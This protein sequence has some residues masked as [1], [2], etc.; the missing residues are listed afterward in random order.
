MDAILS[1]LFELGLYA[2]DLAQ[3]ERLSD[4]A[5]LRRLPE[6]IRKT[7]SYR[8]RDHVVMYMR[9]MADMLEEVVPA[10]VISVAPTASIQQPAARRVA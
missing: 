5:V 8:E 2:E 4:P 9:A 3:L 7:L 10:E 6:D 1:S